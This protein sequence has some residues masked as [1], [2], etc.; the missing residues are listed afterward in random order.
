[1]GDGVWEAGYFLKHQQTPEDFKFFS[2]NI[3]KLSQALRLFKD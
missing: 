1:V 2:R 3:A